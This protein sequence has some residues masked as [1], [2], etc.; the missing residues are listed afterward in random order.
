MC[1]P[2]SANKA[3]ETLSRNAAASEVPIRVLSY[4][5]SSNASDIEPQPNANGS[6]KRGRGNEVPEAGRRLASAPVPWL[7]DSAGGCSTD[8]LRH[9]RERVVVNREVLTEFQPAIRC[10]LR[11]DFL[12]LLRELCPGVIPPN[13]KIVPRCTLNM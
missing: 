6:A 11:R 4:S 12:L 2:P 10:A 1:I 8:D 5:L 13:H 9:G 7:F 3:A